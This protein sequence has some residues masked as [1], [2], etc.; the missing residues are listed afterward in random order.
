MKYENMTELSRAYADSITIQERN[1]ISPVIKLNGG[2]CPIEFSVP[3]DLDIEFP[4]AVIEKQAVF[5][6]DVLYCKNGMP[7]TAIGR[8]STKDKIRVRTEFYGFTCEYLYSLYWH[9]PKSIKLDMLLED[10]L[11]F[12]RLKY[13]SCARG[14]EHQRLYN[15]CLRE[16][17]KGNKE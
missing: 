7:H 15:Q 11:F 5:T 6:G 13:A 16:I 10:V 17:S 1:N 2:I 3:V 4:L 12:S 9:K 8:A 14:V